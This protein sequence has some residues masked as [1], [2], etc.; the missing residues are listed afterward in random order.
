V[1]FTYSPVDFKVL[2]LDVP[3]NNL[4]RSRAIIQ[5]IGDETDIELLRQKY[6]ALLLTLDKVAETTFEELDLKQDEAAN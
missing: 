6:E 3:N 5:V 1:T 4:E 2:K